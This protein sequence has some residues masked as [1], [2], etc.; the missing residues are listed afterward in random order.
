ME[1][2]PVV[3]LELLVLLNFFAILLAIRL[4]SYVAAGPE[5]IS[6]G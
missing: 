6:E 3:R 1:G 5:S 4:P 2:R